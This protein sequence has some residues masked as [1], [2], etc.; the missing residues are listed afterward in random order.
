MK[1]RL[2]I[3]VETLG[4]PEAESIPEKLTVDFETPDN[5]MDKDEAIAR[6]LVACGQ[7]WIEMKKD[8]EKGKSK[9]KFYDDKP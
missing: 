5:L 8:V 1:Y 9:G 2:T 7:G 4:I 3:E 6:T